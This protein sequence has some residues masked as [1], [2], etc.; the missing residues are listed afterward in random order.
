MKNILFFSFVAILAVACGNNDKTVAS[1][2]LCDTTC[3]NDSF[4]F[5]GNHKLKPVINVTQ[6]GCMANTFSWTHDKMASK[7]TMA[8]TALLDTSVRINKSALNCV[9]KDTSY[10][11]LT[12]NDCVSG[13][14]YLLQLFFSDAG[15]VK[16][17]TSALNSF[18]KKFVVDDSL[19]AY[20]DYSAIYAVN[21]NTGKKV[22]LYYKE[23]LKKI[24]FN[25]I[26]ETID[27]INFSRNRLFA[28]MKRNGNT[29]QIEKDV[30]L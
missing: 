7:Q 26:H 24:N 5:A 17:Y 6:K 20:C 11:W 28:V 9:V 15:R 1:T 22:A 18:D 21:V 14:G 8:F 25:N 12:F 10:A 19:R 23:E 3:N 2:P 30:K 27:S 16:K 4:S 13:R 29:E